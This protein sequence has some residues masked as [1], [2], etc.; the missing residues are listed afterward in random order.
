MKKSNQMINVAKVFV[1]IS[2]SG[3][4]ATLMAH[5]ASMHNKNAEQAKCE[6]L[7]GMNVSEADQKDPVVQAMLAQCGDEMAVAH[8]QADPQDGAADHS[9]HSQPEKHKKPHHDTNSEKQD[10]HTNHNH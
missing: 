4:S 6:K 7:E 8:E 9:N 3:T 5:D 10:E 2:L 1:L